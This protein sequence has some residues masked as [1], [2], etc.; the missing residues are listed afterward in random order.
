MPA[1]N[2]LSKQQKK[3]LQKAIKEDEC[4]HFREHILIMLL[5]NDGKTQ[6]QI[7]DFLGCS[8]R[9]ISHWFTHGDP[10]D[11]ESFRDGRGAGNHAKA[12]PEYI[13]L[14]LEAVEKEP[15]EFGYEFG[16]W[17]AQRL[18]EHLAKETEIML[19]SSQVKRLLKKKGYRYIWQKY[20]LEDR[21]DK[22]KRDAFKQKLEK[23]MELEKKDPEAFQI[24]F[25]DESGFSLRV[26]R[27]KQW[28]QKGKRKGVSGKRRKGRVNVMGGLRNGDKKRKCFF[29][30]KGD[31]N[32]FLEQLKNLN[33]F[34][35]EEW[36][37]KGNRTKDFETKGPKILLILDNA[38]FHKR[39]DII[40]EI[41]KNL[42]NIQL[43]FLPAYSP[44]Y[45]LIELVWHSSKEYIAGRLF[46]SIDQLQNL[47]DR[48]LNEG[49]LEIKW[50]RKLKNKGNLVNAI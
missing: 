30:P 22:P 36:V 33:E 50:S 35:K 42:P 41:E 25:W 5:A 29:I 9:T 44:D 8:L 18:S 32:I 37:K 46:E 20:S 1:S 28:T 40:E 19:S 31:G 2:F 14:L 6:Q 38:S 24:W 39:G 13:T 47:L 16:R 3:S 48:L 21:Q 12:T 17:T 34:V 10:D 43:E 11:L 49:K 26:R 45:N 4:P 27:G 15:T 7:S 23:W